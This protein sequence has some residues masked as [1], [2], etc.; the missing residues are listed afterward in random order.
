MSNSTISPGLTFYMFLNI[1]VGDVTTPILKY[2]STASKFIEVSSM[3]F[4]S[5]FKF[6]L[7][8][9]ISYEN[10]NIKVFDQPYL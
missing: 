5:D 2:S 3:I 1:V 8:K 9:L 4:A 6:E 10:G 7:K